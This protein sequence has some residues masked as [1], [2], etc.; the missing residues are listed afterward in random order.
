MSH[1]ILL[2]Y[3]IN[4]N[5]IYN[6]FKNAHYIK[7]NKS[8]DKNKPDHISF[9]DVDKKL[10]ISHQF[11]INGIF[12]HKF[13][14]WIWAWSMP[15]LQQKSIKK[16]RKILNYGLNL[17]ADITDIRKIFFIT[18]RFR[19]PNQFH[20]DYINAMSLELI[21][22]QMIY[23]LRLKISDDIIKKHKLSKFNIIS[24]EL[25]FQNEMFIDISNDDD[26]SNDCIT[27]YLF[28]EK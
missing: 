18:S 26:G 3:D 2:D 8:N 19:I 1:N 21:K 13:K 4:K 9:F 20:I 5:N 14:T 27:Y 25:Y 11:E 10:I 6:K 17:E 24:F 23:Q 15:F 16:S 22:N 12:I 28:L 7:F